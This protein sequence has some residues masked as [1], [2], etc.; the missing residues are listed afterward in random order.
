[1]TSEDT[2]LTCKCCGRKYGILLRSCPYC[3][4]PE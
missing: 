4:C 3:V 2:G 1:M